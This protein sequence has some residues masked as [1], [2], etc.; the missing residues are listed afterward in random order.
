MAASAQP[1]PLLNPD[2]NEIQAFHYAAAQA[3]GTN[4]KARTRLPLYPGEDSLDSLGAQFVRSKAYQSWQQRFPEGAPPVP[5]F[6][7]SDPV[8]LKNGFRTLTGPEAG[9]RALVTSSTSSAGPLVV[10]QFPGLL[11]PGLWRPIRLLSLLTHLTTTTDSIEYS[12]ETSHTLAA[13]PVEEATALTGSSGTKPEGGLNF[14]MRVVPVRTFAV[15]AP[16]TKKVISDAAQLQQYIDS[17]LSRDLLQSVEDQ[18]L[19]GD[20]IGQNFLGLLNVPGTQTAGPPAGGQNDLDVIRHAKTLI[21]V[22]ARTQATAVVLNPTDAEKLDTL[23]ATGTGNY[24]GS[25]PYAGPTAP[26]SQAIWG[27]PTAVTDA[28]PEGTAL[29]GDFNKAVIWDRESTTISIG[30]AGDDFLRNLVRVLA[31]LRCGMGVLRATAF[32]VVTLA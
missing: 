29:V 25:G 12:A 13:E 17:Y 32:V 21:E 18:V 28:I 3:A 4:A 14:E 19:L 27:V 23:K 26:P 5:G 11:E 9:Y 31:E 2:W 10:P 20:G 1:K 22:N 16:A 7:N 30:T 24:L 15:W 6:Y 8:V